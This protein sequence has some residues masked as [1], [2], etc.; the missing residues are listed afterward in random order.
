VELVER[1]PLRALD[2][3]QVVEGGASLQPALE[4][5]VEHALK[6]KTVEV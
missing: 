6:E 4:A 2:F 5:R 3:V 1:A